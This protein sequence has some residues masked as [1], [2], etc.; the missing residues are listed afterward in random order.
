MRTYGGRSNDPMHVLFSISNL[1]SLFNSII[2][3]HYFDSTPY[4]KV[5]CNM[6][7]PF[8]IFAEIGVRGAKRPKEERGS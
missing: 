5:N 8:P 4:P 1:S 2:D 6:R 7:E 3:D